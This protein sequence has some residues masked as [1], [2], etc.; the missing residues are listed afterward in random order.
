MDL[1]PDFIDLLRAFGAHEVRY[2]VVGGYAVSLHSRPRY[3]K[4]IDLWIEGSAENLRR[5]SD[6]LRDF[7][8]PPQAVAD[9][10]CMR[11]T[12]VIFFGAPPLRVDLLRQID[13]V[14]FEPAYAARAEVEWGGV[15]VKVVGREALVAAKL[16]AGRPQD[17]IDAKLLEDSREI[18]PRP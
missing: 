13:G 9:A 1:P 17:L 4:D 15:P 12:E 11:P 3:T 6:A 8:A 14:E 16:A 5:T 7:G 2:L 10:A 18:E